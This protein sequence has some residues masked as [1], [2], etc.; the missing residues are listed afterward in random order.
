MEHIKNPWVLSTRAW[1]GCRSRLWSQLEFQSV[2]HV[3]GFSSK[4][5]P[6]N[7]TNL[8]KQSLSVHR[9]SISFSTRST[10]RS[11]RTSASSWRSYFSSYVLM[12]TKWHLYTTYGYAARLTAWYFLDYLFKLNLIYVNA[13]GL[14]R[15]TE[16]RWP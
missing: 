9:V 13:P 10:R 1:S 4:E 16:E 6:N 14:L 8:T 2:L 5:K 15:E 12:V 11:M 7:T 3:S